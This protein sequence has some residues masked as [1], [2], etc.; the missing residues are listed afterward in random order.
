METHKLHK[1]QILFLLSVTAVLSLM[2]ITSNLLLYLF[3][4]EGSINYIRGVRVFVRDNPFWEP[5]FTYIVAILI[6]AFF[7]KRAFRN[8]E[9]KSKLILM[10]VGSAVVVLLRMQLYS[11]IYF[12]GDWVFTVSSFISQSI[13]LSILVMIG[14]A[15][16]YYWDRIKLKQVKN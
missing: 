6:G 11:F 16:G 2:I 7:V 8:V 15:V 13:S 12:S 4:P 10:A 3:P 1:D 9:L 5:E 14:A